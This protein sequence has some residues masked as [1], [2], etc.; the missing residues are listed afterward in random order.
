MKHVKVLL[1]A[2]ACIAVQSAYSQTISKS[3]IGS[4]GNTLA[5]DNIKLSYTVGETV[6]GNMSGPGAQLG[7]GFFAS[8]NI[9][10]LATPESVALPT[11]EIYPNPATQIFTVRQ[12]ESHRMLLAVTDSDG[13]M[14]LRKHISSGDDIDVNQ[15]HKG[16]YILEVTNL[17]TS[18]KNLFKL[19]R[20]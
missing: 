18:K 3:V 2:L 10:A 15:W 17:T 5:N 20:N 12:K 19:V 14:V 7:N 4:S 8:L 1:F 13:K 6:A 11:V 9:S 16:I